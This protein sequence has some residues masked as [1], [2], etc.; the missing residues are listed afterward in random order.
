MRGC[1][2]DSR[3]L[4]TGATRS[5]TEEQPD[6]SWSRWF[7]ETALPSASRKSERSSSCSRTTFDPASLSEEAERLEAEMGRPGFWD[8]QAAAAETSARHASVRRRLDGFRRLESDVGDLEELA[9]LAA[10]D[11]EMAGELND[12]L[13]SVEA[14]LA[15]L[16]EERLF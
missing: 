3:V 8:D 7:P 13:A 9:E 4:P 14:R 2:A 6:Q 15:E 12:Q 1:S 5:A 11:E 16:E 10:D